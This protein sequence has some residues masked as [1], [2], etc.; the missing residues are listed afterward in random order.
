MIYKIEIPKIKIYRIAAQI[1]TLL[2]VILMLGWGEIDSNSEFVQEVSVQ[3]VAADFTGISRNFTTTSC[4]TTWTGGYWGRECRSPGTGWTQLQTCSCTNSTCQASLAGNFP[5]PSPPGYVCNA[6]YDG[7]RVWGDNCSSSVTCST[8]TLTHPAATLGSSVNCTSSGGWC[9]TTPTINFTGSEPIGGEIINDVENSGGSLCSINAAS[10]NCNYGHVGGDGTFSFNAWAHSSWGDT[11]DQIAVSYQVDTT[12]PSISPSISGQV[13]PGVYQPN[14]TISVNGSDA[15]S[16]LA[17]QLVQVDGGGYV[18]PGSFTLSPGS[19]TIDFI[20]TDNAGNSQSSSIAILVDISPPV[21]DISAPGSCSGAVTLSGVATDNVAVASVTVYVDG[22]SSSASFGGGT[23]S[24]TSGYSDGSHSAYVVVV[25]SGGNS[26]TTGTVSFGTDS[27]LPEIDLT[28]NWNALVSGWL[29]VTDRGV[30][31]VNINASVGGYTSSNTYSGGNYPARLSWGALFP[32]GTRGN[33][34][35]TIS[36]KVSVEDS[37]GN[38][39][40]SKASVY[41]PY[42]TAT[43]TAT[44]TLI[45]TSTQ[46]QPEPTNTQEV[47]AQ[48]AVVENTAVP[49]REPE[50]VVVEE[51]QE[52]PIRPSFLINIAV[53]IGVA[54]FALTDPRPARWFSLSDAEKL[55]NQFPDDLDE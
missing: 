40:S 35:E 7:T 20:A 50:E 10:G 23:W 15:T 18:S 32:E 48:P 43:P 3:E 45:P 25:D 11:T 34:G 27:A 29:T 36:V 49:N 21:A 19:H 2:F 16:G 6:V 33:P 30:S 52:T 4:S 9:T 51:P 24:Y 13:A 38:T 54:I 14:V 5:D 37:C 42:P 26:T 47:V 46:R 28:S 55:M 39:S 12:P 31:T 22:N 8:V 41:I 53:M 1:I 17:S 44:A